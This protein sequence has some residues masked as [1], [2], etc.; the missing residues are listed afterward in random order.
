VQVNLLG[1][2][3]KRVLQLCALIV[4][5]VAF[6]AGVG[7]VSESWLASSA[8]AP[9]WLAAMFFTAILFAFVSWHFRNNWVHGRFWLLLLGAFLLH[10][11]SFFTVL[12]QFEN[13]PLA[14]TVLIATAEIPL[15]AAVLIQSGFSPPTS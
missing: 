4:A 14:L 7:L 8:P 9:R 3:A 10:A 15:I 1:Q 2:L 5:A 12:K 11:L 6:A 13:W